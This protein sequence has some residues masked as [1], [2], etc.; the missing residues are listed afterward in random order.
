MNSTKNAGQNVK[1]ETVFGLTNR[2]NNKNRIRVGENA[3]NYIS[4]DKKL[5]TEN[6]FVDIFKKYHEF[7]NDEEIVSN[8][9]R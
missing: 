7:G 2:S 3:E 6:Y 4:N 5:T 9:H 8:L 1:S